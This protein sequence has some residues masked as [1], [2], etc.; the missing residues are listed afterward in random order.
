MMQISGLIEIT[1]KTTYWIE[2]DVLFD[3]SGD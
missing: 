3:K 2:S 1:K